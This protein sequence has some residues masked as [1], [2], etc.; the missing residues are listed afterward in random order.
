MASILRRGVIVILFVV[1]GLLGGAATGSSQP[2]RTALVEV[3]S[4]RAALPRS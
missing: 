1:T 4:P 2:F 3:Q